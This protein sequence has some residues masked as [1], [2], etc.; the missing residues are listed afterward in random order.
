MRININ[1][2]TAEELRQI[3]GVGEKVA[4]L[5]IRFR[6]I[7]GVV[8]KEALSLALRGNLSSEVLDM[9]DFSVAKSEDP[10]AFDL[11]S[12][13]SVPKTD[14]W[15]PLVTFTHQAALGRSRPQSEIAETWQPLSTRVDV[16]A[17]RQSKP[18]SPKPRSHAMLA[19]S[20]ELDDCLLDMKKG[21]IFPDQSSF[22]MLATGYGLSEPTERVRQPANFMDTQL[23][24]PHELRSGRTDYKPVS[25]PSTVKSN[26]PSEGKQKL[27]SKPKEH[28]SASINKNSKTE[29]TA[30]ESGKS[31]TTDKDAKAKS[32]SQARSSG[33]KS[34]TRHSS[35]H[36]S[37]KDKKKPRG[38]S[39]SSPRSRSHGHSYKPSEEQKKSRTSSNS[40]SRSRSHHRSSR[41]DAKQKKVKKFFK[42]HIQV[43]VTWT[44]FY[45]I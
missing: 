28:Q 29:N 31:K 3:P 15:E 25:Q 32:S 44:T 4:Q 13:P 5:I 19:G 16:S 23:Q 8:K 38:H 37:K 30:V 45:K 42:V 39:R 24:E 27:S 21:Y 35:G 1:T 11:Q 26:T 36:A 40:V 17:T 14:S 10:F 6:E 12:L 41:S 34:P 43:K 22:D 9:I 20:L 33:P 2:A 7:Y 18:I